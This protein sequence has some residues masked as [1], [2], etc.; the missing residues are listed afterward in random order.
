MICAEGS[1][2][3]D[4]CQ[5]DSGGPLVVRGENGVDLEVGVVSWGY[6]CAVE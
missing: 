4:S 5:G 3:K 6:G 1:I 2:N